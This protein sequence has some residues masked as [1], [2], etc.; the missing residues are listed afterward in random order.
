VETDSRANYLDGSQVRDGPTTHALGQ[1]PF[2]SFP[3]QSQQPSSGSQPQRTFSSYTEAEAAFW[4]AQQAINYDLMHVEAP[5]GKTW[6]YCPHEHGD[7]QGDIGKAVC[8][9]LGCGHVRCHSCMIY[10]A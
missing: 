7:N 5:S 10:N 6:K 3:G 1:S 9:G 8:K 2:T 4:K